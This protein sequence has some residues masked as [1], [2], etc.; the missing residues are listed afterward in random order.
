MRRTGCKHRAN[1]IARMNTPATP[2]SA[3]PVPPV[4]PPTAPPALAP[5]PDGFVNVFINGHLLHVKKGSTVMQACTQA[6]KEIPHF[7]YH[8]RLS[9]AGNCR[10]CLVE[11][12]GAPKPV[13]SCHWPVAEGMK[14][15]TESKVTQGARKGTMELL[16]INHPL[17]CPICDQ[18]GEC[19]LQDQ[20]VAYGADRSHFNEMKRAVDDKDIGGKIKTVMTRCIH[21]TRCIR[22][23]TEIAGVEEFGAT[24]R[25]EHMQVGTYVEAALQS[26][27]AGNMIDLC[28]VGALTS[29]PYAYAARPWELTDT[30]SVDVLDAI[31][32]LLTLQSRAGQVLRVLPREDAGLNEEWCTDTARFSYDALTHNRLTTPLLRK[33][34]QLQPVTWPEALAAAAKILKGQGPQQVGLIAGALESAET[35]FSLQ[36]FA[37]SALGGAA[38]SAYPTGVPLQPGH[39]LATSVNDWAKAD[40]VLLIGCNPRLEAPLLNLRLRKL[41]TKGRVPIHNLGLPA[42][43]TY[44]VTQLGTDATILETLASALPAATNRQILVGQGVLARVDA[45]TILAHAASLGTVNVLPDTLGRSTALAMGHTPSRT[46]AELIEAWHAGTLK[47]L[48]LH[49]DDTVMADELVGGKGT[50]V[51]CGTHLSPLAKLAQLVLPSAAHTEQAGTYVNAEGRLLE[52]HAATPPPM[53]AKESWKIYRALSEDL[54]EALPW[55]TLT[56]LRTTMQAL[57]PNFPLA[58]SCPIVAHT[59][60]KT[61]QS[62]PKKHPKTPQCAALHATGAWPTLAPFYQ[63]LEYLKQSTTMHTLQAESTAQPT[64]TP[65]PTAPQNPKHSAVSKAP[66]KPK[67][68]ARKATKAA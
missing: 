17:D 29:K 4:A 68:T 3:A 22:F 11:I 56:Q 1:N 8:E 23:A 49:G 9:I 31:G 7:C 47:T 33:G 16:L 65:P 38:V 6:G 63:R 26:E 52:A 39:T 66:A 55:N 51:F 62:E 67:S 46:T 61:S 54:G 20:A 28:P 53:N 64:P 19:D 12:E 2:Q 45:G 35:L 24:G 48:W 50:L 44:P 30:P 21:C 42:N 59:G 5:A 58:L 41:A 34:G 15:N 40:G 18:G 60:T 10:M 37:A 13:A 27:L 14:V 36:Q 57:Q 32:G 25:G 43:L